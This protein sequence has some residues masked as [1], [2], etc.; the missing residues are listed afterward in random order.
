M[1]HRH[2]WCPQ[3]GGKCGMIRTLHSF[4]V[5][6]DTNIR[7]FVSYNRPHSRV[8]YL[9]T[10]CQSFGAWPFLAIPNTHPIQGVHTRPPRLD[11]L[12]PNPP[13]IDIHPRRYDHEISGIVGKEEESSNGSGCSQRLDR[14]HGHID[15]FVGVA[16]G[17]V[18]LA[19]TWRDYPWLHFQRASRA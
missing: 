6:N 9:A 3:K 1:Y 8:S 13:L 5:N 7:R 4:L 2:H 17:P 16:R 10:T 11:R 14:R 15:P 12:R 19:T 18:G